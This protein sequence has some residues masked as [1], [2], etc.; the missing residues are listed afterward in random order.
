M[1]NSKIEVTETYSES[2]IFYT[3]L[4][5]NA[6]TGKTPAMRILTRACYEIEDHF[7]IDYQKSSLSNGYNF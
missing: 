3:A 1:Q 6:S 7:N 5:A 4:L 2:F